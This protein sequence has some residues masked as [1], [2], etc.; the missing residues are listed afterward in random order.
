MS[1]SRRLFL[2]SGAAA[3]GAALSLGG[4]S[5]VFAGGRPGTIAPCP[6]DCNFPSPPPLKNNSTLPV[7]NSSGHAF[8][9]YNEATLI[10][11]GDA[12]RKVYSATSTTTLNPQGVATTKH[13]ISTAAAGSLN[14]TTTT[15]AGG[16]APGNTYTLPAPGTKGGVVVVAMGTGSPATCQARWTTVDGY[17]CTL[18]AITQTSQIE[19]R[20]MNSKTNVMQVFYA[21]TGNAMS[22]HV[23]RKEIP[24]CACYFWNG[25]IATLFALSTGEVAAIFALS[26]PVAGL[27]WFTASTGF[28]L[29]ALGQSV[30]YGLTHC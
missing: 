16:F 30:M 3:G 9:G 12:E 5:R 10:Y 2:A 29:Y 19:F 24:C 4:A 8:A 26:V 21:N 27:L 15:P 25:V 14:C 17:Y 13:I 7:W 20:F 1:T 23:H 28:F 22:E 18:G 11:H 6:P